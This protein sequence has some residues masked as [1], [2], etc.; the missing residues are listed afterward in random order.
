MQNLANQ[1]IFCE[2]SPN[3]GHLMLQ[4]VDFLFFHELGLTILQRPVL[5]EID[6]MQL[7]SLKC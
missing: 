3:Q 6:D 5:E 7:I 4:I 2:A 1:Y